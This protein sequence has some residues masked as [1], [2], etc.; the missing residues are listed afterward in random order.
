MAAARDRRSATKASTRVSISV[1]RPIGRV[2]PSSFGTWVVTEV[3][4]AGATA[5]RL[6]AISAISSIRVRSR[7]G[8]ARRLRSLKK[9]TGS[10][11]FRAGACSSHCRSPGVSGAV[12]V[13]RRWWKSGNLGVSSGRKAWACLLSQSVRRPH[14]VSARSP[15]GFPI[16]H[17]SE[18]GRSWCRMCVTYRSE[19]P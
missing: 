6:K 10:G 17:P 13:V 15:P 5:P 11:A 1:K 9:L 14:P 18:C 16:D 8:N 7:C 4:A 3:V 19:V 12:S 2:P